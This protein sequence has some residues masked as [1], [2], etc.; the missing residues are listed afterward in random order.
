MSREG[1]AGGLSRALTFANFPIRARRDRLDPR[2]DRG[3]AARE[4]G[5]RQVSEIALCATIPAFN[6][7]ANLDAHWGNAIP[8]VGVAIAAVLTVEA[9]RARR[10]RHSRAT[11]LGHA[12]GSSLRGLVLLVSLPWIAAELGFHFPG[13]FF[14]G[15]ELGREK[16][17]TIAAVHLGHHHGLDGAALML[18][19]LLLSRV[20][21][22]RTSAPAWSC[23]GTSVSC[24]RTARSTSS[25]TPG[26]SSC[27]SAARRTCTSR[28][29]SF[30][31]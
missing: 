7:Q 1:L 16:D 21:G 17:S 3:A 31:R 26:T 28:R 4:R 22:T 9:T 8:A 12:R 23:R 13:D 6:E 2:R 5:G 29:R 15:E 18:T 24:S 27:T 19:A 25:R 20:V 10:R 11:T 14:M 30:P